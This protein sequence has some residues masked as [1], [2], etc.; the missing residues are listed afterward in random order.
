MLR[1]QTLLVFGIIAAVI[2]ILMKIIWGSP[3]V[4]RVRENFANGRAP[5]PIN[6]MTECPPG[7]TMYMYQGKAYCCGGQISIDADQVTDTC[8]PASFAPGSDAPLFCTLGATHEGIPNCVETR[9][10]LMQAIGEEMCP[11]EMP[12][13]VA[14]HGQPPRCCASFPNADYTACQNPAEASCEITQNTKWITEPT[15]CQWKKFYDDNKACPP[16]TS[17][18]QA[19]GHGALEGTAIF[20]CLNQAAGQF[21]VSP[22]LIKTLDSMGYDSSALSV[23]TTMTS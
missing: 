15:S 3:L 1:G 4:T 8:R 12:N 5:K 11:T 13:V 17:S 23:C 16:N 7:S 6:T 14:P 22:A 18:V 9:A 2:F 19:P 21:C 10:G 20:G